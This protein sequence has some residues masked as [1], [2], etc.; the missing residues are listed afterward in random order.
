MLV[1]VRKMHADELITDAPLVRRLLAAQFPEWA[2]LPIERVRSSGTDNALYRLGDELVARL[3]RIE[4]AARGIAKDFEWLPKLAPLLPAEIPVPMARGA[5][6][7]G[8]PWEWGVYRWMEGENPGLRSGTEDLALDLAR[9]VRAIQRV[10]LPDPPAS[11]RGAPLEVQ[12]RMARKALVQLEG[13]IDVA[14][15]TSAWDAALRAPAWSGAPVW[16][17]GDL[18]PGNVL[19]RDT[20]LAGVIDFAIVGVGD[21]ACD[22]LPAWSVLGGEAREVFRRELGADDATWARGRG[23]ALSMGLIALPYYTETNPEFAAVAR[24][25]IGEVLT[26]ANVRS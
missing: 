26:E 18:L 11:R 22:M 25:M 21:P 24:H 8:F 9:V 16:L 1:G 15:A 7:A 23:W 14:A 12:D 19:V 10:E 20:R 6:G 4:G 5:P 3:P 13:T 2:E 17:H